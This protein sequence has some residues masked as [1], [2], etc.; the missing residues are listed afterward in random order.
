MEISGESDLIDV[1]KY[2]VNCREGDSLTGKRCFGSSTLVY[3]L[4]FLLTKKGKFLWFI[5]LFQHPFLSC[6]NVI[7]GH[8]LFYWPLHVYFKFMLKKINV[9]SSFQVSCVWI[10]TISTF[11]VRF[12]WN[13]FEGGFSLDLVYLCTRIWLAW[14]RILLPCYGRM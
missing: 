4:V 6:L 12:M 5:I 14:F 8:V 1:V 10:F 7:F 3:Q 9:F 11:P 2:Q 13:I